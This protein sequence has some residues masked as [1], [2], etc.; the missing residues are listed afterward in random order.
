MSEIVSNKHVAEI[1][2]INDDKKLGRVKVDIKGVFSSVSGDEGIDFDLSPWFYPEFPHQDTFHTPKVGQKVKVWFDGDINHG[3]YSCYESMSGGLNTMISEDYEGFKSIVH[4]L[5]EEL[6]VN[7][8]RKLGVLIRLGEHRIQIFKEE[9]KIELSLSDD[10]H[11]ITINDDVITSSFNSGEHKQV[12]NSTGIS[13]VSKKISNGSLDGSAE[14]SVLGDKNKN[15]LDK[16]WAAI[17]KINKDLQKFHQQQF[18]I[19][20]AVGIL[21]PLKMAHQKALVNATSNIPKDKKIANKTKE[22]LS[23]INTLD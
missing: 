10:K 15:Q 8:S 13:Q 22:T 7:Y 14:P 12:I 2:N 18:A 23:K 16:L 6:D 9:N 3:R 4:D 19:T 21:S 20:S 1:V 17:E 5:E 11:V